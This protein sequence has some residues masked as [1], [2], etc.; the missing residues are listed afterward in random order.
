MSTTQASIS[1]TTADPNL[2]LN[3]LIFSRTALLQVID[4][5]S[6]EQMCHPPVEAGNHAL[7]TMGHLAFADEFFLIKFAGA[8]ATLPST[9]PKQFGWGHPCSPNSADFPPTA[10][11]RAEMEQQRQKLFDWFSSLSPAE[12]DAS[13]GPDWD[14]FAPTRRALIYG[15]AIHEASHYGQLTVVRKS[16]KLPPLSM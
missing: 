11:V 16:L 9:W 6:A 5:L 12:L 14:D 7:W 15:L 10:D 2:D 1:T 8:R 3:P 13:N 4:S